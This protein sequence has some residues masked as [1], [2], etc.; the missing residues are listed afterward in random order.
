MTGAFNGDTFLFVSKD[1]TISGWR[2]ALGTLAEVLQTG[3]PDNVYTGT[4]LSTTGGHSYLLSANFKSGAIDVM[5]GDPG[6]PNL[7]GK[8]TDPNL[9]T[10][11]APY[12]IQTLGNTIY[13]AYALQGLGGGGIVDAFDLQGNILGRLG[14]MGTL[15]DPWGLAIAPSSFGSFAG[16]LLVA[17]SS[18]GTISVFSTN[19]ASP[20][21][22]GQLTGTDGKTIAIDGLKGLITGNDGQGG[23]SQDIYFSAGPNGGTNGLFGVI[24]FASAGAVPEPSSLLLGLAAT[25]LLAG[26]WTWKNRK[27]RRTA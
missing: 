23:S 8:F 10:N 24:E 26:R 3:S 4:T 2:P 13:V 5:K 18:D 21:F 15:H 17:N 16:D 22:L 1:G 20:G 19:P 9:P 25:G 14:T 27:R 11:Y 7:T 6:A 12:N